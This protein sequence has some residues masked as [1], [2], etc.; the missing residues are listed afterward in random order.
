[1][2]PEKSPA[3]GPLC[4]LICPNASRLPSSW[5]ISASWFVV[6]PDH[7]HLLITVGSDM[8][9]ERAIQL[10]KGGFA[11]RAGKE[12]GLKAPIWQKGFSEVR[13]LDSEAFENQREYIHNNPVAA[14]LAGS[15]KAYCYS[16]AGNPLELDAAPAC[17]Q[18][19]VG[20]G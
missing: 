11:F 17:L 16:S 19:V 10:V 12:L 5:E 1:M 9:I 3:I 7:F 15:A 8:T 2:G 6:M 13:V 14:K 20:S 4:D 18:S